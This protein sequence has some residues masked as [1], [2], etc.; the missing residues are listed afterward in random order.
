VVATGDGGL[1]WQTLPVPEA[2]RL[3]CGTSYFASPFPFGGASPGLCFGTPENG[4]AVLNFPGR[5]GVLERTTD[6]GLRWAPVASFD[7]APSDLACQGSSQV[8]VAL[9]WQLEHGLASTLAATFDGGETWAFGAYVA[10]GPSFSPHMSASD[11]TPLRSLGTDS[12]PSQERFQPVAA[13][14][15]PGPGDLVDLWEQGAGPCAP[16]F[17]IISTTDGGSSWLTTPPEAAVA[18]CQSSFGL[19]F[20]KATGPPLVLSMSWP[21]ATD[22]FVLGSAADGPPAAAVAAVN[23]IGTT[24]G[25]KDWVL[26]SRFR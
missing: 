1:T 20:L 26:L 25:G 16:G 18:G 8:W 19:P 3:A 15:D 13:L 21:N 24:D 17:A 12:L 14:A 23:L 4:W 6:S 9:T 7:P 10:P 22:G 2:N 11:G 5:G